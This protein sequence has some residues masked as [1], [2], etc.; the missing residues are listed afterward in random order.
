[1]IAEALRGAF[2]RGHVIGEGGELSFLTGGYGTAAGE[3]VSKETALKVASV[4]GAVSIISSAIRAMPLEVKHDRGDEI[5]RPARDSRL[6]GLLHDQTN[7]EQHASE[8][9]EWVSL[10]LLLKGNAY[11]WIDREPNGQVRYLRPLNPGRVQVYRD[12]LTRRKGFLVTAPDDKEQVVFAGTTDDIL[13][14]R[15]FGDDPLVGVSVIHHMREAIG[16]ALSEDRHAATTMKNQGRPSGVLS[17]KGRLDDERATSLARRWQA[18]HGGAGKAGRVAVLEEE[19][20]WKPVTM[21]AADLEL[22]QQ[23][24]ISREDIAIAFQIPGDMLLAGNQANLHYST[25]ATRDVRLVK[26]AV[27]PWA[28]RIQDALEICELLPWGANPGRLVP[29]FNPDG[30]LRADIKTRYEAYQLGLDAGWLAPDEV[31]AIED[32]EPLGG[33]FDKPKPPLDPQPQRTTP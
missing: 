28:K 20:E 15:G 31:R 3:S 22:V 24:A 1:M 16:R 12:Q 11:S 29:R 2:R 23:R 32:R 27:M 18:A 26:H 7:P 17:I 9:W 4:Y 5:L 14:F 13:H 21:S 25:D 10:C 6:W 8:F 19:A 30:L 33:T